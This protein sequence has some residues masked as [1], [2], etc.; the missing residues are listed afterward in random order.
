M[1]R[2]IAAAALVLAAYGCTRSSTRSSA[3][4]TLQGAFMDGQLA[5]SPALRARLE[6]E[7]ARAT[8]A[9]DRALEADRKRGAELAKRGEAY[10]KE[11]SAQIK[12]RGGIRQWRDA[13]VAR[14]KAGERGGGA[15]A[16]PATLPSQRLL[17]QVS[18]CLLG[19]PT[20]F[21][22]PAEFESDVSFWLTGCNIP[23]FAAGVTKLVFTHESGVVKEGW[24]A[25]SDEYTVMGGFQNVTGLLDGAAT[26]EFTVAPGVTLKCDTT[27]HATRERRL[28]EPPLLRGNCDDEATKNECAGG[29]GA[30]INSFVGWH[31]EICCTSVSG[32][33]HFFL[34]L[35]Q[36]WTIVFASVEPWGPGT[37]STCGPAG[38]GGEITATRGFDVGATKVDLFI[39]WK[40]HWLCSEIMYLGLVQVIGPRGT[41]PAP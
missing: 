7:K 27:F 34:P 24:V 2:L 21:S 30:A 5:G 14:L 22:G 36:R 3:A 12:R 6:E 19:Q 8:T 37:G 9:G 39:D 20:I 41:F 15:P 31:H 35:P 23:A 28:L 25:P 1:R 10:A 33:D 11:L 29:G 32:T 38:Q 18:P 40:T 17:T 4:A 13:E 26:L 16:D